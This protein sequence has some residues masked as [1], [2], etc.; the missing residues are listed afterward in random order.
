MA[1]N[2]KKPIPTKKHLARQERERRQR[3]YILIGS[4]AVII[5]VVGLIIYGILDA[6]IL[7]ERQP[8]AVVNGQNIT[9]SQFQ[10]QTRYARYTLIRNALN[11]YQF[12]Q[13]FGND[14]STQSSFIQQL[15]QIQSQL[16]PDTIGK[17]VLDQLVDEACAKP[18]QAY[19]DV[20]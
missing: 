2:P 5:A 1:K 10:A 17:Q 12:M 13:L 4:A 11:T 18:S 14:P 6:T 20:I 7:Q 9:T 8:V 19:L 16:T 15:Q 3:R